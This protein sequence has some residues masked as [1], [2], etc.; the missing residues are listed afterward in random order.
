MHETM[1][2]IKLQVMGTD[3]RYALFGGPILRLPEQSLGDT[4]SVG[5]QE[6]QYR[7]CPIVRR[8]ADMYCALVSAFIAADQPKRLM[9]CGKGRKREC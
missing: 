2:G 6:M 9:G 3:Q 4:V 5:K 7:E 8:Y 1:V